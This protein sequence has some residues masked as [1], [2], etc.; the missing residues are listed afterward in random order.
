MN[1]SKKKTGLCSIIYRKDQNKSVCMQNFKVFLNRPIVYKWTGS[2]KKQ[3][4]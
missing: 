4:T 3:T 1:I 2:G